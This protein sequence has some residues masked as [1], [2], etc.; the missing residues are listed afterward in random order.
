VSISLYASS[1][2]FLYYTTGILNDLSCP[3]RPNHA[4]HTIGWGTEGN[5]DY[6]IV[7][8]SWG[9]S[10]GENGYIRMAVVNT[11]LGVCG[12]FYRVPMYPIIE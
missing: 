7:R 11:T 4:V 2:S 10:W 12:M 9:A 6:F 8:N 1:S 3:T 5:Q